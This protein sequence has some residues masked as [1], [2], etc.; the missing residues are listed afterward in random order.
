MIL[1]DNGKTADNFWREISNHYPHVMLDEYVIMPNHIHGILIITD[2][3]KINNDT[4]KTPESGVS[5]EININEE[6]IL[7]QP[8]LGVIINQFKRICTITIRQNHPEFAWQPRFYD[9]IIRTEEALNNI[10][11]YIIDNPIRWEMDDE[12]PVK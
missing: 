12:N 4:V 3:F 2:N 1:N 11:Q 8:T 5:T 7:K 9:H 6:S 10:R